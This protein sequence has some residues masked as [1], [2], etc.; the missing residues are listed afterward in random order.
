MNYDYDDFKQLEF[1]VKNIHLKLLDQT[2][3]E[4]LD[5]SYDGYVAM[6]AK[7]PYGNS[8]RINDIIHLMK[9]DKEFEYLN[10][11]DDVDMEPTDIQENVANDIHR[12]MFIIFKIAYIFLL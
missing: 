7:R 1:K 5:D 12:Q 9:L 4:W 8:N 2:Y 11:S 3:L 6:N 10:F